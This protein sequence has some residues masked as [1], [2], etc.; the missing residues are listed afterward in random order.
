MARIGIFGGSF[1]PPHLGHMLAVREFYQKLPLDRVILIPA[2][3]PPHKRLS[4]NSATVAQR[5]AMTRLAASGNPFVEVSDI[6]A[7]R[8]G[9]SY[10][11]DTLDAL[12]RQYPTD[13]LFLLMGTDMFFSF[14]GWY[15]PERITAQ[16]TLAVAHR[17]A[18]DPKKLEAC[19]QRLRTELGARVLLV[20]NDYLT[21]SSTEAR[22]MLAF[23]C[24][25]GLLPEPVLHY[26]RGNGLYY[27]GAA[28]Q[29]LPFERLREVSL[30]LYDAKRVPHAIGCSDTAVQLAERYGANVQDARRAGILHDVT[31]ALGRQA[32]LH[33]CD[34]Y[35]IIISDFEREN[36][37]LLHAKTGAAVAARV[38]GENDAICDAICWHTTGKADMTTLE[39]IIYIADYIEPN[40]T[41][42]GVEEMRT[43][44]QSSLDRAVLLGLRQ[45]ADYLNA[46]GSE[47]D[48]NTLAALTFLRERIN[49]A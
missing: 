37:K 26:I 22:A 20:N 49:N 1:N 16:A 40:R 32:Q 34:A 41:I 38:F 3:V 25:D 6:E 27:T 47:L 39:K 33:L 35:G 2:A 18:D 28:L 10:T 13:E 31:K 9:L 19:A 45:S 44:A 46:R 29:N 11:A 21:L 14:A 17:S 48:R 15:Q 30:S 24:A 5:L 7:R 4:G 42:K 23:R 43:A 8:E 12:R 36:H